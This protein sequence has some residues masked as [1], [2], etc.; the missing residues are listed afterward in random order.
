[1][2][3]SHL[4][5][6]RIRSRTRST[7]LR[8]AIGIALLLSMAVSPP[9]HGGAPASDGRGPAP[10]GAKP[11][12]YVQFSMCH[13]CAYKGWQAEVASALAGSG[14]K[15]SACDAP[16][17]HYTPRQYASLKTLRLRQPQQEEEWDVNVYAGPMASQRS[18][19]QLRSRIP[20]LLTE[21]FDRI[22]KQHEESGDHPH[23]VRRLENCTGN[24]CD[25]YGFFLQIVRVTR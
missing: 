5:G 9:I 23:L 17:S 20:S 4:R 11:G 14:V 22:D 1:M 8:Q 24:Q 12:F 15:A 3:P 2:K 16:S 10:T 13:A 6:S 19:A 18:A 25:I 21:V 7:Y